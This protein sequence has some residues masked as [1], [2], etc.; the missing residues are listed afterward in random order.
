[1]AGSIK[2]LADQYIGKAGRLSTEDG[3]LLVNVE[4]HDVRQAWGRTDVQVIPIEGAGLGTV[5]VSVERIQW[6]S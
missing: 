2:Q 3:K 1:M 4:C 6:A 5:W